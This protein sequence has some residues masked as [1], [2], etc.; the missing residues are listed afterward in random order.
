M[1]GL[2][3]ELY[4]LLQEHR[5][6]GE[7]DRDTALGDARTAAREPPR[8][9]SRV[10]LA[11]AFVLPALFLASMG[12]ARRWVTEDAFINLRVVQHILAGHGPV[13]NIGER[14][15]GFT[16]PLWVALLAAWGTLGG[17]PPV[18]CV[19][20][21]LLLSV[22]GLLL[23]QQ[24]AWSL[25]SR[26]IGGSDGELPRP[27]D[28]RL[29]F[30]LGAAMFVSVPVVWDFTT[31]GLESGLVLAWLGGAYWLLARRR[32]MTVRGAR[33]AA[34]AIGCGPLV[35]PDLVLFSM[36]LGAALAVVVRGA[37]DRRFVRRDWIGL[38]I[39]AATMP[40]GYQVFRMGFFAA[41]VP[42]TALAKEA[43]AAYWSQGWRYTVDFVGPYVLWVPLLVALVWAID[44]LRSARRRE[45]LPSAAVVLA[46]MLSALAHWLYVTRMGGDFMHGRLLLPSL[47]GFLLPLATVA[48]TARPFL[49]WRA[50]TLTALAGWA[51]V[52]ALWLR[53][54]YAGQ[55]TLGPWGITDERGFYSYYMKT[56]NPTFGEYA[57]HPAVEQYRR[58]L[59]SYDRAVLLS[60]DRR[61]MERASS[62]A[63]W[64]PPSTRLVLGLGN[65]GI[66]GYFAGP[67]VHVVDQLG[68][69]DPIGARVLLTERG[70]P[71]HE[72]FLPDAWIVARFANPEAVKGRFPAA[73]EA[74][75]ALQCGEL[76]LLL[77][78]VGSPLSL[79]RFFANVRAAWPL[80]RLRIPADPA[81]AR[82]RFCTPA[83][84]RSRP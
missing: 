17:S 32:P 20:L 78:A 13:F 67:D 53:V 64:V 14:V 81:A 40:L 79:S 66:L 76:A 21:G 51:V 6:G 5:R 24:G 30:P 71:G 60:F 49:G 68:L 48:F 28:R 70:R 35:R 72:K 59:L 41:L 16:S 27:Q 39:I 11:A 50:V 45:D 36:G 42:N 7:L 55:A 12:Y 2:R 18:G 43:S 19:V 3:D 84:S 74:A 23:A 31:S 9:A 1:R 8:G 77:R 56:A 54:P 33:I 44:L 57:R 58:R 73:P 83:A 47:F 82:D 75:R 46:P 61:E 52:S 26:L 37:S 22:G 25:A 38:A 15:E 62:L 69:T 4:A 65:I 63:A 80:H 10:A 29:A 34:F